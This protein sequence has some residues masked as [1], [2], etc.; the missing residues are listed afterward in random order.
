MTIDEESQGRKIESDL[1]WF[2]FSIML[3][4]QGEMNNSV[5]PNIKHL[6]LSFFFSKNFLQS[7]EFGSIKGKIH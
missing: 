1:I 6:K 2:P 3:R 4:M 7:Y 5:L